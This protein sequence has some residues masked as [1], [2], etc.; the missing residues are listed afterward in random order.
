MFL[1]WGIRDT[2]AMFEM[3][4]PCEAI[5]SLAKCLLLWQAERGALS[6]KGHQISEIAKFSEDVLR[7]PPERLEVSVKASDAESLTPEILGYTQNALHWAKQLS[8]DTD[9]RK[10][11]QLMV[12]NQG[13][14]TNGDYSR[15]ESFAEVNQIPDSHRLSDHFCLSQPFSLLQC[16]I[17]KLLCSKAHDFLAETLMLRTAPSSCWYN[18]FATLRARITWSAFNGCIISKIG[19]KRLLWQWYC[20][21]DLLRGWTRRERWSGKGEA[22]FSSCRTLQYGRPSPQDCLPKESD[23]AKWRHRYQQTQICCMAVWWVELSQTGNLYFHPAFT[24]DEYDCKK[25]E[26]EELGTWLLTGCTYS[27]ASS[28]CLELLSS[29]VSWSNSFCT[30]QGLA[31]FMDSEMLNILDSEE[32]DAWSLC[33]Q[34]SALDPSKSEKVRKHLTDL[35]IAVDGV[36]DVAPQFSMKSLIQPVLKDLLPGTRHDEAGYE[37]SCFFSSSIWSNGAVFTKINLLVIKQLETIFCCTSCAELP[38]LCQQ[39]IQS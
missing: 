15:E 37:G 13:D 12:K 36:K 25:P 6:Q 8:E 39:H 5:L 18:K 19:T 27:A 17:G 16:F 20:Y 14:Q 22:D 11:K 10:L 26:K 4:H 21:A 34:I 7:K 3:P 38:Y 23:P 29:N 24:L 33:L 30:V 32:C 31:N 1:V 2:F 28:S 9:E 35:A